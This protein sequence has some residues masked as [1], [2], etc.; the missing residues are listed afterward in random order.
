MYHDKYP[1]YQDFCD[2]SAMPKRLLGLGEELIYCYILKYNLWLDKDKYE[3]L[4]NLLQE[5]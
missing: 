2:I 1:A 5:F 4:N 3:K